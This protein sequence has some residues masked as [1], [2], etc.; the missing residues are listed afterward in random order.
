VSPTISYFGPDGVRRTAET[1]PGAKER[2]QRAFESYGIRKAQED[3]LA[4]QQE[5]FDE[6][7]ALE[8]KELEM[9]YRAA[10]NKLAQQQIKDMEAAAENEAIR[11]QMMKEQQRRQSLTP[12]ELQDEQ[13]AAVLGKIKDPA[14]Q[15]RLMDMRAKTIQQQQYVQSGQA[16]QEE[17][18]GLVQDGVIEEQQAQSYAQELQARMANG[19]DISG[20]Q[21]ELRGVRDKRVQQIKTDQDWQTAIQYGNT[22]LQ[23]ATESGFEP[24]RIDAL[25]TRLIDLESHQTARKGMD[26]HEFK[27]EIDQI[28]SEETEE[29]PG[30]L[31]VQIPGFEQYI[32]GTAEATNQSPEIVVENA[33]RGFPGA[34]PGGNHEFTPDQLASFLGETAPPEPKNTAKKR[35]KEYKDRGLQARY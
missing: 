10:E 12:E 6:R 33:K 21:D 11:E 7:M 34:D 32:E 5:Q 9:R 1:D 20:V 22:M 17:I 28:L 35:I 26:P 19:Q 13:F 14:A 15:K 18:A 4:Q 2:Q 23:N 25:R 29:G 24:E 8:Q 31:P 3:R 30:A 16:A 27:E